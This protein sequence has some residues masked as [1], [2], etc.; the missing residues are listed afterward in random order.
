MSITKV[1]MTS[2]SWQKAPTISR[3]LEEGASEPPPWVLR[4]S[5]YA[6][7]SGVWARYSIVT[8]RWTAQA[9]L[10]SSTKCTNAEQ[11][12]KPGPS[13]CAFLETFQVETSTVIHSKQHRTKEGMFCTRAGA[14]TV[15]F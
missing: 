2:M 10:R 8:W 15:S 11:T 7:G 13:S 9:P 4:T 1:P 14:A 5:E 12:D 6:I 3:N